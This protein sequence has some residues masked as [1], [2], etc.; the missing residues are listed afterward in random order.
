MENTTKNKKTSELKDRLAYA[1]KLRDK[2]PVDLSK[3]LNIPKSAISQYLSGLSKNMPN[4]R[5]YDICM[6]LNV[7]EAWMMGYDVPMDQ[8]IPEKTGNFHGRILTDEKL[9]EVIEIYYS[10]NDREQ[11]IVRT[12]IRSLKK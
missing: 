11:E 12:F 7:D 8:S 2:K 9:L 6:Y 5:L 3:D 4:D 10:L 1:L